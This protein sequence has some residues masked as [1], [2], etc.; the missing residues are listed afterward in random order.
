MK[1]IIALLLA[2]ALA[3]P[4]YVT[5]LVYTAEP[6]SVME[7]SS[8][9]QDEPQQLEHIGYA[10]EPSWPAPVP[11]IDHFQFLCPIGLALENGLGQTVNEKLV[12]DDYTITIDMIVVDG[13]TLHSAARII[14][15]EKYLFDENVHIMLNLGFFTNEKE[16][17]SRFISLVQ[18]PFYGDIMAIPIE[19]GIGFIDY[20]EPS[21]HLMMSSIGAMRSS[22]DTTG[23]FVFTNSIYSE[24]DLLEKIYV[25]VDWL[26]IERNY[27][28]ELTLAE[29]VDGANG[30]FDEVTIT[31]EGDKLII[32][33]SL[34]YSVPRYTI[35]QMPYFHSLSVNNE[36]IWG[37]FGSW[38]SD[39]E[40]V[41]SSEFVIPSDMEID[42]NEAKLT[43]F[44]SE[45]LF[46]EFFS[47]DSAIIEIQIDQEKILQPREEIV[48]DKTISSISGDVEINYII[49][50]NLTFEL[51]YT[52]TQTYETD[53][54]VRQYIQV[55]EN[56]LKPIVEVRLADGSRLFDI[57]SSV[58]SG[59]NS[60]ANRHRYPLVDD[61]ENI[62]IAILTCENEFKTI[63]LSDLIDQ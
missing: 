45:V 58:M 53:G 28:L 25:T 13:N 17:H 63:Y 61:V 54:F 60:F 30:I 26:E 21:E 56:M 37:T 46:S 12:T 47:E 31:Q 14:P 34:L 51:I 2:L 8:E 35:S 38:F 41:M 5:H 3:V 33:T 27:E 36:E 57:G 40:Y 10:Q 7:Y 32:E 44:T 9:W 29:L 50:N 24:D 49:L 20:F 22:M 59:G 19:E 16:I 18:E 6:E 39:T 23:N 55:S 62:V 43:V 1:K 15:S 4:A 52:Y 11:L 48:V 42:F